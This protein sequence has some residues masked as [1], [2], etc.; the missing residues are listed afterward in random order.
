M[1]DWIIRNKE[2]LFSGAGISG[3]GWLLRATTRRRSRDKPSP[4]DPPD[5]PQAIR[6]AA[7]KRAVMAAPL[8]QQPDIVRHYIGLTARDRGR[9]LEA[10]PES[11]GDVRVHIAGTSAKSIF[12]TVN[13]A[14]H[15]G[16]SLLREGAPITVEG[17][18]SNIHQFGV[19]LENA[20]LYF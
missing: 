17:N 3:I 16:L 7:A 13:R 14:A 8:L 6:P 9:L 2:W 11:G 19:E 5:G 4:L 20:R 1:L 18:I 15:P 10:R 12:C